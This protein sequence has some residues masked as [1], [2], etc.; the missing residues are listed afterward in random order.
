MQ[1]GKIL[2]ITDIGQ[3]DVE[4]RMM[5][6]IHQDLLALVKEVRRQLAFSQEDLARELG[7]SFATVNRRENAQVRPSKLAMAQFDAFC[8]KM[9]RQ[10]KLKLSGGEK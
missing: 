7:L 6:M 8:S 10:G 4:E 5:A 2:Q 9:V 1:F 3:E